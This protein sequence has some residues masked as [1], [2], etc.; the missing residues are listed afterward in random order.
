MVYEGSVDAIDTSSGEY[1]TIS[2]GNQYYRD[3]GSA[4]EEGTL[5]SVELDSQDMEMAHTMQDG[6][7]CMAAMMLVSAFLFSM[8]K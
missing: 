5:V 4:L 7:C 8:K 6:G 1:F 3:A 2:G